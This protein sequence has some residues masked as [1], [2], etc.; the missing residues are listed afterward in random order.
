MSRLGIATGL[1]VWA[2]GM[3][4]WAQ[5]QR[6]PTLPPTEAG[7]APAAAS[8][9]PLG[10]EGMSVIMRDGSPFLIVGTRLYAP[11]QSVGAFKIDRITE[12]EVWLRDGKEVHKIPRFTGIQRTA[13]AAK[14]VCLPP[15]KKTSKARAAPAKKSAVRST[16]GAPKKAPATTL[17]KDVSCED[18]QP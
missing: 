14:P 12:T 2:L 6:D 18:T 13:V 4:A 17:S 11:G 15:A 5:A 16:K 1:L 10:Q 7:T 9:S 8:A 3:P